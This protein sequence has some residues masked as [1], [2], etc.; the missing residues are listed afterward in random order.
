[1]TQQF[2]IFLS[3]RLIASISIFYIY[4]LY[5]SKSFDFPDLDVYL[6]SIGELVPFYKMPNPLF[7]GFTRLLNYSPE[8]IVKPNFIIL[9]LILNI[10]ST[11]IY[12][13]IATKILSYRNSNY[14]A[15]LLGAHPYLAFYS[16]KI[17]TFSD[18]FLAKCLCNEA[19]ATS[20]VVLVIDV[21]ISKFL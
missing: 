9:S 19:V 3:V 20:L 10:S 15:I 17:D 16:L 11:S 7:S 1:M 6:G 21:V 14:Y 13:Y 5:S 4:P 2:L 12:I 8:L 18:L